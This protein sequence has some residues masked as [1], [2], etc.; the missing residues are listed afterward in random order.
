MSL[1]M[2]WAGMGVE[3]RLGQQRGP[4]KEKLRKGYH[5]QK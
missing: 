5:V 1:W 4:C 2:L 3:A